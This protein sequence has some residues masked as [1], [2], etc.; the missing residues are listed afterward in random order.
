MKER[1]WE[2]SF[3]TV[4]LVVSVLALLLVV[5]YQQ[6]Q[7]GTLKVRVDVLEE[8]ISSQ[9]DELQAKTAYIVNLAEEISGSSSLRP[10]AEETQAPYP[11]DSRN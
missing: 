9:L 5:S 8:R 7:I 1:F 4:L 6:A 10:V 2:M 11:T 3:M